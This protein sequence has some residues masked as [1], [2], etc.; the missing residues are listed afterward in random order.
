MLNLLQEWAE[1]NS[2]SDNISGLVKMMSA[3]KPHFSK[4]G[5][6]MIEVDLSRRSMVD[7]TGQIVDI[8][9]GKA[10]SIIKRSEAPIKVFFGGHMDTVYPSSHSFQKTERLSE[11]KLRGPG[12]ADMKGGLIVMLKALEAFEQHPLS[13]SIGWEILINPDEEVGSIGSESLLIESSKRNSI[14][15]IFEPS[16]PDGAIVSSRKGSTSLTIISHGKA[17]HAGRD[18][19]KG[20]NAIT[21]LAHFVIQADLLNNK[22]KGITVNIGQISGGGP[23]NVVPDIAIC[24]LNIRTVNTED[25]IHIQSELQKLLEN[26][27]SDGIHLTLH[28]QHSRPPKLFDEKN[29]KLFE[30]I[31][32]CAIQEGVELCLKP[33]GGACDGNILSAI[34]LPVIDSLGVIGGNIHTDEEYMQI[35]SLTAR[36]RIICLFLLKLAQ[37]EI[38]YTQHSLMK[39]KN[40]YD[41]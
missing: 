11:N 32:Q 6:Q 36:A 29:K 13:T 12:V 4:L 3:L 9:H 19:D 33:S 28:I 23:V 39:E 8:P 35:D 27:R 22:E 18:Y 38:Q 24:R 15:L 1:I 30:L 40:D 37:G 31:N 26:T 10:L 16:F 5:G 7:T 34:G 21:A 2:H 14:G 41:K 25:F 20:R 17:A